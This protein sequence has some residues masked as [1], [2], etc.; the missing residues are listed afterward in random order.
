MNTEAG[1][2]CPSAFYDRRARELRAAAEEIRNRIATHALLLVVLA[3][4]C[5]FALYQEIFAKQR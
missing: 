5:C 2:V 3:L 4:L 1:Q